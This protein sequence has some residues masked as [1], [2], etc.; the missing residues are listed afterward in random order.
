MHKVEKT[1]PEVDALDITDRQKQIVTFLIEYPEKSIAEIS[2]E[3][4]IAVRTVS[5]EL[6][7]LQEKGILHRVGSRKK[8]VWE[9]LVA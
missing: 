6:A 5:R 7:I 3:L 8:G 4:E 2:K 1:L 9:I